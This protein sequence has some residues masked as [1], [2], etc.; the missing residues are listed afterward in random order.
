M[1]EVPGTIDEQRL[2]AL[3]ERGAAQE[4]G[5]APLGAIRAGSGRRLR[6]R[7]VAT[8]LGSVVVVLGTG[9]SVL[10][11]TGTSPQR[12]VDARTAGEPEQTSGPPTGGADSTSDLAPEPATPAAIAAAPS[13]ETRDTDPE[14]STYTTG[15]L[16][17]SDLAG[18]WT[19][20][21]PDGGSARGE[22]QV[23]LT[24]MGRDTVQLE[25]MG[26]CGTHTGTAHL[27]A[28]PAH[29]TGF[30][31]SLERVEQLASEPECSTWLRSQLLAT[32]TL[33]GDPRSGELVLKD[34]SGSS[35]LLVRSRD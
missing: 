26:D 23:I 3:L 19:L 32:T 15:L 28:G 4:V 1:S 5:P 17:V 25:A 18:G 30:E 10:A 13:D 8:V 6:R 2:H 29:L 34:A 7:R 20:T 33:D 16:S 11:V 35:R 12:V 27:T 9:T 31:L 22:V 21:D 24:P 14:D